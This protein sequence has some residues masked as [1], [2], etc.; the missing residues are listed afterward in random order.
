MATSVPYAWRSVCFVR[1]TTSGCLVRARPAC[2][3]LPAL[4]GASALRKRA[5]GSIRYATL[6]ERS[7]PRH[8]V[9]DMYKHCADCLGTRIAP[10]YGNAMEASI[11][12]AAAQHMLY[13]QAWRTVSSAAVLIRVSR[14]TLPRSQWLLTLGAQCRLQ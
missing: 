13:C 7:Q 11:R 2:V 6:L 4:K 14:F 10:C 1:P 12:E 5:I 8:R 9:R 3:R